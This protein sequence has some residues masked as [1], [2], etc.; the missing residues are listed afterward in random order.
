MKTISTVLIFICIGLTACSTAKTGKLNIENNSLEK[1]QY[2]DTEYKIYPIGE[3]HNKK[4]KP[5][6]LN[7]YKQYFKGLHR[8]ND[9]SHVMVLWWFHKNNTEQKRA[10]LQVHP[11][12]NKENLLTGVFA[13]RSP[14]RPN[15]IA[16]TTCKIISVKGNM[17]TIDK[18]DAFDNTPI[19]DL[20]CAGTRKTP[21]K[22]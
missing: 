20:K 3:I 13:T 5:V 11:R 2:A 1:Q 18:I 4:G 14:V 15:L 22:R 17:V 7:V 16:T 8:L 19:I 12:G 9:C 21:L 10:I 6:Q